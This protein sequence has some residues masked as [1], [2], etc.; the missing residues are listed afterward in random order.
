MLV[1]SAE[2]S[3]ASVSEEK[4]L[5]EQEG[6]TEENIE[7]EQ[8]EVDRQERWDADRDTRLTFGVS[9]GLVL[10]ENQIDRFSPRL[11]AGIGVRTRMSPHWELHSRLA[12]VAALVR[13]DALETSMTVRWGTGQRFYLGVG[14]MM[15]LQFP[16]RAL[17]V[18]RNS[19]VMEQQRPYAFATGGSFEVGGLLGFDRAIDLTARLSLG[20]VGAEFF[21]QLSA[22][23]SFAVDLTNERT[24]EKES[25]KQS[26]GR[27]RP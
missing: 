21:G 23:F 20:L 2:S 15:R 10:A 3:I 22:S 18:D 8:S 1:M 11:D 25:I 7:D 9:A 26:P 13:V 12:L 4:D 14:P 17:V 6:I 16:R 27:S 5:G 24:A 19:M